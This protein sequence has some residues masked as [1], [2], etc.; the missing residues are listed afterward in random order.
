MAAA[1]EASPKASKAEILA[2]SNQPL[3]SQAEPNFLKM[4]EQMTQF[5][6][7]LTQEVSP[8]N[9]FKAPPFNTPS[10]K[11]P[12]SFDGTQAHKLSG[13][14][15]SFQL[16]FHN[17]PE[18]FFSD[19]KKSLYSTSFLT[20]RAGKWIELY[21]SNISNEDPS[22]LLNNWKLFKKHSFTLFGDPKEVRKAEQELDNS[23]M[24]ESGHVSLYIADFR[25][26]KFT[27]GRRPHLGYVFIYHFNPIIKWKNGFITYDSNGINSSTSNNLATYVN[28]VSLVGELKTPSLPSPVHIP[29]IMSSYSL[30]LSRDEVFKEIKDVAISSLHL[31]QGDM[32]LPPSSFN[33]SLEEQWD[34]EE[35]PEEI[36]TVL[37]VVPPAYSQSLDVFSK[38]KAEKL[39]PH[40][41]CDHHIELEGILP[42]VGVIY[43]LSNQESDT[44]QAYNSEDLDKGFIKPSSSS[45]GVP[46]LFVKKTDGHFCLCVD[47]P[48]LN[49]VTRKNRY[50]VPPM[51]QLLIVFNGSTIFSKIDLCGAY[52]LLRIKEG[53]EQLTAFGTKYGIYEYMVMPFGL[54]NAPSSKNLVNDIFAEF[55]DIFVVFYSDNIMVF[56]ISEEEHVKNLSSVLQRLR[57]NNLS[58][59]ASK[60]LFHSSS[61]EYLGYFVSSDGL[62]MD[63]SKVQKI[64]NWPQPKN[65]KA[66]QSFLGFANLYCCFIEFYYERSTSLTSLLKKDSPFIFNEEAF[67]TDASD[68]SL[69][70]VLSKV[71]DSGMHP[72]AFDSGTLLP[73]EL[74]YEIHDT[75]LLGIV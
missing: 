72:I 41:A 32:H 23:R 16:I 60:F 66:L 24:K 63:S 26:L 69:G 27:Q 55:L 47:Y 34:E 20:C 44:L 59:K 73:A 19:R 65:L 13:F 50:P 3:F 39:P 54:T 64:L 14:I 22:Y 48:K 71:N 12:D 51:N 37:R 46:V 21:L 7:K 56:S 43:S 28:S 57:D 29:S 67:K 30:H 35:E 10:I 9:N 5:M 70:A 6:G 74:N 15:Q 33:E 11:A 4:M 53:D 62:E 31:V 45:R 58:P 52:N 42:P 36:G 75:E 49:S 17:D 25:I 38:V 68:Y 18:N 61:V 2:H 8:R 1:L 40:C